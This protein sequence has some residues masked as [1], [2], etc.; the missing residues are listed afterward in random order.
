MLYFGCTASSACNYDPTANFNDGTCD[1]ESCVG[2]GNEA[3]CNYDPA[4]TYSNN[5]L[6]D[7]AEDGYDCDGNCLN[8]ADGDGVCDEFEVAG[9]QDETACNYDEDATDADES[10]DFSC[11][12]CTVSSS[13]NYD[14]TATVNDGSCDFE[15]CV[16]CTNPNACNFDPTATIAA[17]AQCT[18]PANPLIEDCDG[19]C[20][21][22]TDGDGVCDEQEIYGCT[23]EGPGYDP[24]ATEDDGSC[25]VGGASSHHPYSRATTIRMQT[26]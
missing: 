7:F 5:A 8:D 21:N 26:T 23:T 20:L 12:G 4:V 24:Y 10:C 2:C 16:G 1:Y 17:N 13:C 11:Y 18:F 19:N 9:C 14:P 6:C 22:D 25:P 15:S 3:A